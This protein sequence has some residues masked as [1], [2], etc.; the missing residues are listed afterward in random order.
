M[1]FADVIAH[2]NVKERLRA[3]VDNGRLP[4]A[5]LLEGPAG[6]GKF[7]MAR[8]LSQ[9]IHCE[10]RSGGDSCG[11]CPACVQHATFNHVDM[12][13][14]FP[15]LKN[16]RSQAVSDDYVADFRE[17][18][19]VSPFMNFEEW[20]KALGNINGQPQMY[21]EESQDILRKLAFT[22][23]ASDT[24]IVLMWLPEKMNTQCANKMLKLIEEPLPGTSLIF[25]SNNPREILPTIY[26]RLQ[27]IE[28]RRLGDDVVAGYL[29]DTLSIPH[30]DALSVAHVAQGSI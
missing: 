22:A 12:V 30:A 14:S 7:A 28:M 8:A 23:R 1:R 17:F 20:Q 18:L 6:V 15:V 10:N 24:K 27:R 13:Y 16:G 3:L 9:Y 11:V 2:E 21:V 29:A 19:T 5:L 4:H 25:V 26:S